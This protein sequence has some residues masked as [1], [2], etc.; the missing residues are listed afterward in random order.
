MLECSV[1]KT[2][3]NN[4]KILVLYSKRARK[5]EKI[6]LSFSDLAALLKKKNILT[7]SPLPDISAPRNGDYRSLKILEI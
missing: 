7:L 3:R 6:G 4:K 5:L 1:V 2:D